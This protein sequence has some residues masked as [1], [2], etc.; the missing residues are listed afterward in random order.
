MSGDG[1]AQEATRVRMRYLH[2][3]PE[4]EETLAGRMPTHPRARGFL[5]RKRRA[6][7]NA[8]LKQMTVEYMRGVERFGLTTSDNDA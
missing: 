8:R 6:A 5:R 4:P 2:F 7:E 3:G 1:D